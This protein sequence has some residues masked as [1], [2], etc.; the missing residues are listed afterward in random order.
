MPVA[1]G[2]DALA[3]TS[4]YTINVWQVEDG[5]PQISVTS[6]AQTS[7]GYL[8]VGTFN[9]LAR[10]DGVRFTVFDEGYHTALPRSARPTVDR[11]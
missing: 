8:W 1:L 6:I 7:D 5:L 4:D 10:F 9:G 3:Y 2:S 11:D